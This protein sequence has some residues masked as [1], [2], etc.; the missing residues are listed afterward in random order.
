MVVATSQV[1]LLCIRKWMLGTW[2]QR[3]MCFVWGSVLSMTHAKYILCCNLPSNHPFSN[4]MFTCAALM[5]Y[6]CCDCINFLVVSVKFVTYVCH[7]A[8]GISCNMLEGNPATLTF[9]HS[10]SFIVVLCNL[11]RL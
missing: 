4:V 7:L 9:R 10:C 8:I 11:H 5:C 2:L 6:F 3:R 1:I